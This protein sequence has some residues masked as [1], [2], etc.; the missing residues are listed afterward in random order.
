MSEKLLQ[1]IWQHRLYA[2][3]LSF[4]TIE[5]E[6]LVV[7][8]PGQLNTHAGPDFIEAK[9]KIGDTVWVGHVELHCKTSDWNKHLHQED[10][11]YSKL[12]LH[13]VFIHDAEITTWDHT[14][15]PTLE[16]KSYIDERLLLRYQ[17]FMLNTK[18]VSCEDQIHTVPQLQIQQQLSRMLAER[19]DEK[20]IPI[21]ESLKR[22]QNNWHEVF[23]IQLA[24]GFGVHINQ[25]AFEQLALITPISILAKHRNNLFQ[26]EALLFGQAGFLFDY[27]DESY[28]VLLQKEYEYLSKLYHLKPMQKHHWKF[29]RLRPANFPTLR[30]AQFA[31]II[32]DAHQLFS[33]LIEAENIQQLTSLFNITVSDYW[34][35]HYNFNEKS[36]FKNKPIGSSF[37]QTLIINTIVPILFLYGKWQGKEEYFNKAIRW[38]EALPAEKNSIVDEWKRLGIRPQSAA[39]SQALLQLRNKYCDAR[40]CLE[41]SIGY[42][43]L[44]HEIAS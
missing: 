39:D 9:I 27:F 16:L 26:I 31:Q 38:L 44:K 19:L 30:I 36:I 42:A 32:V 17:Q 1:F 15:F 33:K 43:L 41:C 6:P 8:H 24:R 13:V 22:L 29:L 14:L 11:R 7:L 35:N 2:S 21:R 10:I 37:M 20:T 40:R 3:H 18:F 4:K 12:I 34:L 5:G 25:D 23:Y 28:P